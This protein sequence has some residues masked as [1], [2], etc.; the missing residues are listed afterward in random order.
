MNVQV[1]KNLKSKQGTYDIMGLKETH[2]TT[3]G[4]KILLGEWRPNFHIS[5]SITCS[6]GILTL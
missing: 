2:L 1:F 6:K 5:E 3:N 4:R